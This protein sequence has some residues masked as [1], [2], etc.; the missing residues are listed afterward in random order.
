MSVVKMST[1][2]SLMLLF[3]HGSVDLKILAFLR[4]KLWQ[5]LFVKVN[6]KITHFLG[7]L[8]VENADKVKIVQ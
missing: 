7:K 6:G 4:R 1:V 8:I 2:F 5:N 3:F